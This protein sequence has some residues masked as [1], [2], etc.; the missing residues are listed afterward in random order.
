MIQHARHPFD[1]SLVTKHMVK[2][3]T[4]PLNS[5]GFWVASSIAAISRYL[6]GHYRRITQN[7]LSFISL[8]F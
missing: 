8:I 1:L 3:L 2:Y 5:S 6:E 4:I 7:H